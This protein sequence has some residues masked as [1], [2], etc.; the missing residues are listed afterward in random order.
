MIVDLS[1]KPHHISEHCWYYE[2]PKGIL[3]IIDNDRT[4]TVD[5]ITIPWSKLR[6]SVERRYRNV[7]KKTRRPKPDESK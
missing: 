5:Q 7:I 2:E 4:P 3:L 1:R 6:S